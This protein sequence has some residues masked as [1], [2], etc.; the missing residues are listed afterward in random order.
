[1][2]APQRR[3]GAGLR[4]EA[5]LDVLLEQ[6]QRF[7]FFQAVR[8]LEM[9][10]PGAAEPASIVG[11]KV[12]FRNSLSLS[13]PA[14]EIE[15]LK[16]SLCED[17]VPRRL[18]AVELTPA[19]M[20]LLGTNGTLPLVYTEQLAWR[21]AHQKD[22]AAR[23]FMDVF[24]NRAL[25]LFYQAW[26]KHRLH[27]QFET[28]R[29]QRFLPLIMA[30][31]GMGQR[32][33]RE[34]F[35]VA[36]DGINDEALAY[37]AGTLQQRT[38]SAHQLR[39]VLQDYLSVPV[40]MEQFI[41]RWYTIPEHGRTLLGLSGPGVL[42]QSAMLGDRVWQRDLRVRVVLGPLDHTQFRRYLPGAPGAQALK[43]LLTLLSGVSLEWEINLQLQ[44][45]DVCG[46]TL[47]SS[48]P[49]TQARLGWDTFLLTRE[50]ANDRTDVCYD[51]HAVA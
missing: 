44:R 50:A 45:A 5:A 34:R 10:W 37:Y 29:R 38:L 33:L 24:S 36:D 21:E 30:L 22:G 40:R 2:S 1:M 9:C 41:G 48:R 31:S 3:H 23:A 20:G 8:L 32:G 17:A 13:F 26:K 46:S 25:T 51:I 43:S 7:G 27:V 18:S 6:P 15:S 19:F 4:P 12:R 11:D 49:A 14:S 35:T 42:G 47:D 28:D 16:V 39:Q